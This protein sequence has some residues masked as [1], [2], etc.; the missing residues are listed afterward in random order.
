[1]AGFP[2]PRFLGFSRRSGARI[3][4]RSRPAEL[5]EVR[6]TDWPALE[7]VGRAT[8]SAQTIEPAPLLRLEGN[9]DLDVTARRRGSH[10]GGNAIGMMSNERPLGATVRTTREMRRARR[11]CWW[12]MRRSVVSSSSNPASS[13]AFNSAPLLSV[14]QPLDCAVWTVCPDSART[15]PFGRTVI[16]EDEHRQGRRKRAD[17]QP[18][19]RGRPSP[20]RASRRTAR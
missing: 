3:L 18:R 8:S 14:S 9:L 10:G 20:V 16:K 15:S 6:K 11:F 4:M 17:S 1:M 5:S 13:A 12:R 7:I 19:T 2:Q